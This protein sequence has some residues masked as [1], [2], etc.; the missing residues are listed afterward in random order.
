MVTLVDMTWKY[1][2]ACRRK[3][4]VNINVVTS[5][6]HEKF[7][8]YFILFYCNLWAY[9]YGCNRNLTVLCVNQGFVYHCNQTEEKINKVWIGIKDRWFFII[10]CLWFLSSTE[11]QTGFQSDKTQSFFVWSYPFIPNQNISISLFYFYLGF[12]M[13]C[14]KNH[15]RASICFLCDIKTNFTQKMIIRVRNRVFFCKKSFKAN[16][17]H[18]LKIIF[19]AQTT[20]IWHKI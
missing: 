5:P 11:V 3:L 7:E 17:R 18:T 13:F 2:L 1:L 9:G 12:S 4:K 6:I 15:Q 16:K 10:L 19:D 20:K 14:P 8:S